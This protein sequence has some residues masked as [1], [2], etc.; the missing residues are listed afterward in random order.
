M[1]G[2]R[3]NL[4]LWSAGEV[5]A[6][7]GGR[8]AASRAGTG[9]G[10]DWQA[11]GVSIDSRSCAPG[12]L[13]IALVGPNFDGHDFVAAAFER[14]A[15][16]AI[17]TQAPAAVPANANLVLV[18]DTGAALDALG[19][20]ARARTDAQIVAV[21]GSVGKTSTK[22]ALAHA[23]S[24]FGPTHATRGNLNNQW[25]VPLSLARMPQAS[26][27]GVFELGM[28][29]AGELTPLSL[30]VRPDVA[31]ITTIGAAHLEF[32]DSVGAIA[33]AKAEIFA[34]M[35]RDGTAI[36][37]RDN[38]WFATLAAAAWARDIEHVVGFGESGA[39]RSAVAGRQGKDTGRRASRHGEFEHRHAQIARHCDGRRF[40]A[41][42]NEQRLGVEI[43]QI[44]AKLL[45]AIARVERR[46]RR[47]GAD[48]DERRCH[49]RPVRQDD[50]DP[51]V[52]AD[53]KRIQRG[54]GIGD[55][56]A[57]AGK[58]QRIALG[59]SERHVTVGSG[60]DQVVQR[61]GG[62][63]GGYPPGR[64]HVGRRCCLVRGSEHTNAAPRLSAFGSVASVISGWPV[65]A[66]AHMAAR[67]PAGRN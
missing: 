1:N 10:K 37:N 22:E 8:Q 28:N 66:G 11:Q 23:L 18:G 44:E 49:F 34:G 6:A 61:V 65:L 46:R 43:L 19:V 12:D 42:L 64:R 15:T 9:T 54:D 17:V 13:F 45:A 51:I 62:H 40:A 20:F 53:A 29:H 63:G 47:A 32:F 2:A 33:D 16:A 57:Q 36:L 48:G 31:I 58:S 25:G 35:T 4:P 38:S 24:S 30:M 27:F 56:R 5:L 41:G 52:A 3:H 60:G 67:I 55:E 7:T 59:R 39:R 50:R 21:T 26:R 14:G